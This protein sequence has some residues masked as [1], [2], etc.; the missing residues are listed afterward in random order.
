MVF[1]EPVADG[2]FHA[3]VVAGV[4]GFDPLVFEELVALNGERASEEASGLVRWE[5]VG[6][7]S[8]RLGGRGRR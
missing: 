7:G 8:A 6:D 5:R 2:A 1:L 4:P 3:D